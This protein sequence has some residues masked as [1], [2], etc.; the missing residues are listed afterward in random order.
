[1]AKIGKFFLKIGNAGY[2]IRG[3]HTVINAGMGIAI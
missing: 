3:L 2:I 1:M